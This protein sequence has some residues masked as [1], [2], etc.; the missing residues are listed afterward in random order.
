MPMRRDVC[1]GNHQNSFAGGTLDYV[2]KSTFGKDGMTKSHEM[3]LTELVSDG[4]LYAVRSR[5][6]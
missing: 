1:I 3:C 6:L 5:R 4:N 2:V